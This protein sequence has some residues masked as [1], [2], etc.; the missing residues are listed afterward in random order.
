M[1]DRLQEDSI[2]YLIYYLTEYLEHPLQGPRLVLHAYRPT[3][4]SAC[5][6]QSPQ[7]ARRL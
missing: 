5:H 4:L 2:V 3:G 6:M 7:R 1:V